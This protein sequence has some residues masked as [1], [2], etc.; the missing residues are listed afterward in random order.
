MKELYTTVF[1]NDET[2]RI[3]NSLC[4]SLR[5]REQ[6]VVVQ[7]ILR[8]LERTF[9]L[10]FDEGSKH[11]KTISGVAALL[12]KV[13]GFGT[14]LDSEVRS[15]LATGRED[16]IKTIDLRRSIIARYSDDEG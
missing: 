14:F 2:P 9:F 1:V 4:T 12:S 13:I 7:S 3:W 6:I 11:N 5:P 8:D 10:G 15:W 16:C